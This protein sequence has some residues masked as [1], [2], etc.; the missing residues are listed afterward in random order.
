MKD[1]RLPETSDKSIDISA[2][3]TNTEGIILAYK[4]N[5]PIGFIGY[6]D[7]NNE[8]VYL[9]DITINCSYKRDENLLALQ[10][11]YGCR[12]NFILL[13]YRVVVFL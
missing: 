9:D 5:K 6:D 8:W 3:D 10:R 13:R 1:I 11:R 4:G 12:K 7:D 2:I